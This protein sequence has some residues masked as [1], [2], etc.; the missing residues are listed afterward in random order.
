[1]RYSRLDEANNPRT[2][3]NELS[4][5]TDGVKQ[6]RYNHQDITFINYI[7][8]NLLNGVRN[9]S[10]QKSASTITLCMLGLGL[11]I[12]GTLGSLSSAAL[13]S[14]SIPTPTPTSTP[15]FSSTPTFIQAPSATPTQ[16]LTPTH[17]SSP[18][19]TPTSTKSPI[20]TIT[21]TPTDDLSFYNLASCLPR[22]TSVQ[23]GVVTQVMDGDTINV[24]LADGLIYTVRY[25]GIDAPETDRPFSE[26]VK[27]INSTL[28]L[29]KQVILVKDISDMD[30]YGRLLRYVIV[31]QKF[32]N[33][34]LVRSGYAG[35]QDYP[36][37][38]VCSNLFASA[39][40]DAR[41]SLLGMWA[42]TPTPGS[43]SPQVIIIAVNKQAEYVDIKNIGTFDV[44]LDGWQLVSERGN[45]GC[46]LSGILQA[47]DTLRIWAM[48]EEGGYSCGYGSPIWNNS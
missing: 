16:T 27:T 40:K 32:V 41:Y 10:L 1:M 22:D 45:Q 18:T 4:L 9:Q 19:I 31:D 3:H 11:L 26:Q 25:I 23:R 43:F 8:L 14:G 5:E 7:S 37:D 28:V 21:P 30:Q 2:R 12:H 33:L 15:T 34:E 6:N 42:A 13:I 46:T 20:P 47:G 38:S 44:E 48:T 36:P 39:E 35:A 29:D 17:T 24:R